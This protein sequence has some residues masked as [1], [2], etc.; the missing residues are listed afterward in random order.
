[1]YEMPSRPR[2]PSRPADPRRLDRVQEKVDRSLSRAQRQIE[3][4]AEK[5]QEQVDRA[6]EQVDRAM[7]Q[8]EQ[9]MQPLVW[10]REEPHARRSSHTRAE[11]AAAA[12]EIADAEGFDA[13]SMRRVAQ[14]LGAGTM[15]LYHYVANKDELITLMVDQVMAEV[16]VPDADLAG[17]WRRALEQIAH[18][19]RDAFRN[20]RWTLDRL[21]DGRPG[22]NGIR[23]FEQTLAAVSSLDVFPETKFELIS[24]IDDYVF[25]FVLREAQELEEHRRGWPPGVL[26]FFQRELDSGDFP[27]I[28]SFLGRDVEAGVDRISEFLFG[29]GRFDR[30]LNRLLDGIEAGLTRGK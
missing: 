27:Q 19:T 4:S 3:R 21:G 9:E 6:A 23:H 15:T 24:Q 29:E 7:E 18:R 22:P 8:A 16:L 13:V 11:I 26:D 14:K 17:D 25:G 2:K 5:A 28:E 30:G 12:L 1:M 10:L 20:H